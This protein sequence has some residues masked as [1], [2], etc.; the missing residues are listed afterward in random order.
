MSNDSAAIRR[1]IE[2][3]CVAIHQALHGVA[4]VCRHDI[5]SRRYE[6]PDHQKGHLAAVIGES[7]ARLIPSHASAQAVEAVG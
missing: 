5:M 2:T 6:T 7:E 3:A 1:H 4:V